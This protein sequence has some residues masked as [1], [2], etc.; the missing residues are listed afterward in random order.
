MNII[1][2]IPLTG[3]KKNNNIFIS[4]IFFI[5]IVLTLFV[6]PRNVSIISCQFHNVTG[7][8]CPTC[9]LSRSFYAM[10][11]LNLGNAFNYHLLGP[12]FYLFI[13]I[14][15]LK[16]LTEIII[17]KEI[18]TIINPAIKKVFFSLIMTFWLVIWIG[19][20]F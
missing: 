18:K 1:K 17:N 20:F 4:V 6:D 11:H 8:S 3:R 15:F 12:L 7:Y 14:L 10:A 19:N 9:G 16:S 2:T 5:V 13:V